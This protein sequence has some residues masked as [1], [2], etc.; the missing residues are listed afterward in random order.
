MEEYVVPADGRPLGER[1]HKQEPIRLGGQS[2]QPTTWGSASDWERAYWRKQEELQRETLRTSQLMGEVDVL[3]A[4]VDQANAERD[5]NGRAATEASRRANAALAE[6]DEAHAL[7]A[8]ETHLHAATRAQLGQ[9][10]A[11]G[12]PAWADRQIDAWAEHEIN[13]RQEADHDDTR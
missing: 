6:R 7:L 5:H 12:T 4:Q 8:E 9:L 2:T 11:I 1:V 3:R 13:A 10:R